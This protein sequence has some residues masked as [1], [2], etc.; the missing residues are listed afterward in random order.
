MNTEFDKFFT[1]T[2]D[3]E[4]KEINE[5]LE[6]TILFVLVGNINSGKSST[7][8]ALM[9]DQVATV[10]SKP[11]E[12]IDIDEYQYANKILFVDTP[13][14]NDIIEDNSEKTL[15]YYKKSDI[16]LFFLNAAGDVLSATEKT[17]FDKIKRYND[18]I[19]II[20]NKIDAAEDIPSLTDYIGNHLGTQY[21]VIPISSKTGENLEGLKA[22]IL[23]ILTVKKKEILFALGQAVKYAYEN[24]IELDSTSIR[25]IYK[26][27]KQV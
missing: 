8:N 6:K 23:K 12:T 24:Q 10:S 22:E 25:S 7:I 20:L 9:G 2:Y 16:I 5:Q 13:G 18:N 3:H 19:I 26:L 21:P 4:M 11:G 14:L 27:M 17:V 15:D 1:D